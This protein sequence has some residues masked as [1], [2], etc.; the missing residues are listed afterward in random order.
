MAV[1]L[2]HMLPG[3][4]S[5]YLLGSPLGPYPP[6]G[7]CPGDSPASASLHG[8]QFPQT[9]PGPWLLPWPHRV[10]TAGQERQGLERR[11]GKEMK[12]PLT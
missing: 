6:S 10:T 5:D 11:P 4:L 2:E 9:L 1:S 12:S 3:P 7:P 8:S